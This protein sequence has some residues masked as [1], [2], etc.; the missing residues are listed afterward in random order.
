MTRRGGSDEFRYARPSATAG[1]WIVR[2]NLRKQRM[3]NLDP[4]W[5]TCVV[6]ALGAR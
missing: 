4:A 6:K 2:E 3:A 5:M 1:A